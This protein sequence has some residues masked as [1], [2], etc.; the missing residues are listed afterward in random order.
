MRENNIEK[1]IYALNYDVF[2]CEWLFDHSFQRIFED[3][4]V[5]GIDEGKFG[6]GLVKIS[7]G[8]GQGVHAIR[9]YYYNGIILLII[10]DS[11]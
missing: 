1:V 7:R 8:V 6:L 5:E 4:V 11:F 9:T 2:G 10:S 3:V